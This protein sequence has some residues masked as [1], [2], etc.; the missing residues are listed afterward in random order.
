MIEQCILRNLHV[1]TLLSVER[2][3]AKK[4]WD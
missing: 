4:L 3:R 2:F 1:M